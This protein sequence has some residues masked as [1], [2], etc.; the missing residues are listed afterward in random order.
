MAH[1]I[2]DTKNKSISL[3]VTY[4][5]NLALKQRKEILKEVNKAKSI[6]V[7][8]LA[9]EEYGDCAKYVTFNAVSKEGKHTKITATINQKKVDEDLKY[10]G[11][12][13]LVTS[14]IKKDAKEI[15]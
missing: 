10:A 9:K 1:F 2:I 13:L 11:Y 6:S 4:N 8:G 15:Y 5:Q 12:N 3:L 7:K 14:E